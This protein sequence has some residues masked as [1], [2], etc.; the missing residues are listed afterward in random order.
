MSSK[1]CRI[2][3][4]LLFV[5]GFE[6]GI[7]QTRIIINNISTNQQEEYIKNEIGLI[8]KANTVHDPIWIDSDSNFTA[9]NGVIGGDGTPGDPYLISGWEI[10]S[11]HGDRRTSPFQTPDQGFGRRDQ[12]HHHSCR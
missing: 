12:P 10:D 7:I 6:L 2:F 8:I 1:N 5:M 9:A 4:I 11:S 3:I